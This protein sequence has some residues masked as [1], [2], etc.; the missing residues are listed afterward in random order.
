[1]FKDYKRFFKKTIAKVFAVFLVFKIS[2]VMLMNSIRQ[3]IIEANRMTA[4]DAAFGV[5]LFV[6]ALYFA[7]CFIPSIFARKLE[8]KWS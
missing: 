7:A 5:Y 2:D 8:K 4:P 1:M 6:F 3:Q